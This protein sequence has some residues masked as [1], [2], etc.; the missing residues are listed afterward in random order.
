MHLSHIVLTKEDKHCYYN[1]FLSDS[2][3]EEDVS[4]RANQ[5]IKS[6]KHFDLS[7]KK[8]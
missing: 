3:A 2:Q 6:P 7:K 1:T 4:L 8:C 5:F